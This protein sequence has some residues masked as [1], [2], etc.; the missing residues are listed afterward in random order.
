MHHVR[1]WSATSLI[2]ASATTLL[3]GCSLGDGVM[4][5]IGMP[6]SETAPAHGQSPASAAIVSYLGRSEEFAEATATWSAAYA[7]VAEADFELLRRA[8]ASGRLPA[9]TGV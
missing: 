1:G 3:T 8:V 4:A 9:E 2:V 6:T 5:T 7:D